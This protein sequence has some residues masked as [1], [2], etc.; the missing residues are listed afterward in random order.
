MVGG[1]AVNTAVIAGGA[2]PLERCLYDWHMAKSGRTGSARTEETYR[3]VM[4]RFRWE[5]QRHALDLDGAAPAVASV[6]QNWAPQPWALGRSV[7]P[8]THNQRLAVLSSF[9]VFAMKRG[10]LSANPIIMVERRPQQRYIGARALSPQ[11]VA[12]ALGSIDRADPM[13]ARDYCILALALYTGR[14]LA[15]LTGLAW[16]D[17]TWEQGRATATFRAKGGKVMTDTL[18]AALSRAIAD[19]ALAVHGKNIPAETSL[20]ISLSHHREGEPLSMGGVRDVCLRHLGTTKFHATRHTFA[21]AM[22][23]VGAKLTDIQA[24]LGHSNAST[25]G[26]YLRA[27]GS[28]VNAHGEALVALFGMGE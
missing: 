12:A 11:A 14:R 25:T 13:G 9:Y 2:T 23:A 7:G 22:E 19:Y 26:D 8:A 28:A 15:E 6:A 5:L 4:Q 16:G 1:E 3:T 18:P 24:R 17:I 27:L 21:Q 10:V 20:W